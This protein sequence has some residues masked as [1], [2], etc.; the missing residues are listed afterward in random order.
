VLNVALSNY[1][2]QYTNNDLIADI[3]AP[4]VPVDRQSFQYLIFDRSAQRLDRTTLRAPGGKPET[5]R[6]SFSTDTYFTKSHALDAALPRETQAYLQGMGFDAKMKSVKTLM[7]KI[8]LSREAELKALIA[9]ATK[10]PN[11]TALSGTSMWD[12]AAS[13]PI[14]VVDGAKAQIRQAGVKPT[15]LFLSDPVAVAL[16]NHPEIIDRFKYTNGAGVVT[17]DFLSTLFQ[18]KVVVASAVQ[19]DAQNVASWV[20]DTLAMVAHIEPTSSQQ[21]LSP[22][23]TFSWTSAPDTTEGY[24]VLEWPDAHLSK[25][26]DWASVD[27]Y[28]DMKPTATET[29]AVFTGCV[30][31]PTMVSIP[32]AIQG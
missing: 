7:E 3:V 24:G 9:D 22:V 21:D 14:E 10:F 30:A 32:A 18:L 16:R 19:L 1:A 6:W 31:A 5:I 15:H 27:W 20:W 12:N 8:Q 28:Y 17:D 13:K 25:K 26:T 4:R 29:I 23:K 11:S 2:R